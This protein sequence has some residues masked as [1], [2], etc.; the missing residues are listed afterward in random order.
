MASDPAPVSDPDSAGFRLLEHTIREVFPES[1][2]A[3]SLVLA[4]TDSRYYVPLSDQVFRFMPLLLTPSSLRSEA[5]ATG[6]RDAP[7]SCTR[8]PS[9]GR[10]HNTA[11]TQSFGSKKRFREAEPLFLHL[12]LRIALSRC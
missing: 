8:L 10:A 11:Q 4:I 9:V 12:G 7:V 1:V 2:V 3:P 5:S 6:K